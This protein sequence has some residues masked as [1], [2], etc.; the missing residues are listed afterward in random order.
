[1]N[2]QN[3]ILK[4]RG[5]VT[6]IGLLTVCAVSTRQPRIAGAATGCARSAIQAISPTDTSII[7]ATPQSSPVSYCDVFGYVTT[8][9][10]GPNKVGFELALPDSWNN[11]FVFVG[12][13][14]FGSFQTAEAS[15][16]ILTQFGFASAITDTGHSSSAPNPSIDA[17]FALNNLGAQDDW[18]YRSVHVATVASKA[19]MQGYYTQALVHSYFSGC[20]NGGRQAMV[21][22]EQFPD[23][24]DGISAAAPGLGD[25]FAGWNWNSEQ[26][27]AS[28]DNFVPPD[29]LKL[30]D[31]A[32][33]KSC[34]GA[35]SCG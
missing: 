8:D 11:R 2:G 28:A 17:T 25:S 27:T 32:I 5:M 9:N 1:M 6:L 12:N 14:G 4:G 19:I 15:P 33:L 24:Y 30:L 26:V 21:E 35:D 10:P 31:A 18:L 13:G 23:D 7:S 20:S 3:R 29:K 34:D 22:A 16:S